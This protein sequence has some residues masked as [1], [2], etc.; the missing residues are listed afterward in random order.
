MIGT[1]DPMKTTRYLVCVLLIFASSCGGSL[2]TEQKEQMKAAQRKQEIRKVT[3]AELIESTL[4]KGRAL[5]E[6]TKALKPD[7]ITNDSSFWVDSEEVKWLEAGTKN[8]LEV[9]KQIIEAYVISAISGD[10]PDNVQL[11]GDSLLY[12]QP[13]VEKLPDGAIEIRGM[14][15]VIFQKKDV[16]LE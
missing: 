3:E 14:W 11:L 1:F 8:A 5:I 7:I 10:L 12:T 13:V 15:S 2:S 9:E 16:I 4:S 6:K